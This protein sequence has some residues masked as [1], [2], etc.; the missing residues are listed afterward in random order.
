[1]PSRPLEA[2]RKE[3]HM[4]SRIWPSLAFA[5][6]VALASGLVSGRAVSAEEIVLYTSRH[7]GQEKAFDAFTQKTGIQIKTLNG[8]AGQIFER[9][10][11]EAERSPADVF[12]TV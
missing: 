9:L 7:Y 2:R 5:V 1:M 6:G 11:A 10:K 12:F 4:R 3:L 8:D